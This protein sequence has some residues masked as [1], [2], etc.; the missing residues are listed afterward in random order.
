MLVTRNV[1][2]TAF[3]GPNVSNFVTDV[4]VEGCNSASAATQTVTGT[5]GARQ[6]TSFCH[7]DQSYLIG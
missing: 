4:A 1:R 3:I 2:A 6:L 7:R 5:E